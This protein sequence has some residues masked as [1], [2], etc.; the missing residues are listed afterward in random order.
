MIDKNIDRRSI[1]WLL[2][3]F[4]ATDDRA[5]YNKQ[6]N[7]N[8]VIF[9][10]IALGVNGLLVYGVPGSDGLHVYSDRHKSPFRRPMECGESSLSNST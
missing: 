10:V 1:T 9:I 6:N 5:A 8:R 2:I 4:K 3:A 7:T